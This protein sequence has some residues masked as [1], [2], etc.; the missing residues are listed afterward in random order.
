SQTDPVLRFEG[1]DLVG[2]AGNDIFVLKA[3]D[4][5]QGAPTTLTGDAGADTFF[6]RGNNGAV[7]ITDFSGHAGQGDHIELYNTE[8][9]NSW[10]TLQGAIHAIN[11]NHD[12]LI[13]LGGGNT[14]TLEGVQASTLTVEDFFLHEGRALSI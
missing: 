2:T 13:D 5:Q 9:G 11:D 8:V 14:I 12:T 4:G 7:T 3:Q 1:N 10:Q 6:F